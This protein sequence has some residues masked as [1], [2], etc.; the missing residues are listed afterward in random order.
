MWSVVQVHSNPPF[1]LTMSNKIAVGS[2]IYDISH[3]SEQEKSDIQKLSK[4]LNYRVNQV[5]SAFGIYDQEMALLMSALSV[6]EE[7]E[8][9][10]A[11]L[12]NQNNLFPEEIT[13][14]APEGYYSQHEVE[15]IL[16]KTISS[17]T[18]KLK[19]AIDEK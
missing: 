12:Q 3:F 7:N 4:A 17:L 1:G 10:K 19:K 8:S 18:L 6:L 2:K 15:E 13:L 9:L 5:I 16:M 14:H 11:N